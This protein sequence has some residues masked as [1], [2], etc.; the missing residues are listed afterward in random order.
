MQ[1]ITAEMV[2]DLRERTGAGMM[3]CKKALMQTKSFDDAIG[4]LREKGLAKAANKAGRV[5][6]EGLV[7]AVQKDGYVG[8]VELNCET[9]FVARNDSFVQLAHDLATQVVQD[10][11]IDISTH[12][13][14]KDKSKSVETVIRDNVATIG[15][16][17]N[18]RRAQL[19]SEGDVYGIYTHGQ[20][21]IVAV[22]ELK[23]SD[24]SKAKSEE[25]QVLAKDLAMHAAAAAPLALDAKS[26]DAEI[27]E[28]ERKIYRQ[29][30]IEQ[31][32]PEAMLD[33]IVDGRINK[34]FTEVC[35]LKQNFVK[36]PDISIEKLLQ[37]VGQSVQTK[38]EINQF[39]R[40]KVGEGIEKKS[41][42]FAA[43]VN[44]MINA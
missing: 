41:D 33:K 9:D 23:L 19:L 17:I 14:L 7:C 6:A 25:I 40:M 13:F 36:N 21:S 38:I 37:Q 4:F 10:K 28:K 5:A 42:D 3:D 8:I 2:R 11:A 18:L 22:V 32:K 35:L 20:G 1:N 30:T 15:E 29:Q 39:V 12:P 44:K 34:Y 31:G 26:L 27:I 43:E 24:T 16:N